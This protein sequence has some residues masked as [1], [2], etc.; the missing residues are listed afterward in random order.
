LGELKKKKKEKRKCRLQIRTLGIG[1]HELLGRL[2]RGVS[3]AIDRFKVLLMVCRLSGERRVTKVGTSISRPPPQKKKN[4]LQGLRRH[5]KG[6]LLLFPT[7]RLLH[8]YYTGI[9]ICTPPLFIL[10]LLIH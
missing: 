7:V 3:R 2:G 8:F 6:G 5:L 4:A 10:L 9:Y 1:R